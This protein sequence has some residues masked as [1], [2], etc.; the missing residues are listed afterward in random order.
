MLSGALLRA[1]YRALAVGT[2]PALSILYFALFGAF[3]T[4]SP[5]FPSFLSSRGLSSTQIA[6]LL[7]AGTVIRLALGPLPSMTPAFNAGIATAARPVAEPSR[8]RTV[9]SNR[10]GPGRRAQTAS[11]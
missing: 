4:E 6:T 7:A 10:S 8:I 9:I 11:A 2:F 1:R 3:G 5:F